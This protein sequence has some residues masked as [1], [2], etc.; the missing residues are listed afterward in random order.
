MIIAVGLGLSGVL[1]ATAAF[2]GTLD[3]AAAAAWANILA[4]FVALA[5]LAVAV[6]PALLDRSHDDARQPPARPDAQQHGTA[7]RDQFN[8]GGNARFTIDNSRD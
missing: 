8:V 1:L 7:G 4:L 5:A 3:L 6:V 2:L